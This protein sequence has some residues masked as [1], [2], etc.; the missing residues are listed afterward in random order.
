MRL[1]R[2]VALL[3]AGWVLC[4]GSAEAQFGQINPPNYGPGYRGN[5]SPYLNLRRGTNTGIDYYLGTRSEFQRRRDAGQFNN[6]IT[7]LQNR[8]R[9]IEDDLAGAVGPVISGTR[10]MFNTNSLYF[11]N[12]MGYFAGSG[13]PT[14]V[15]RRAYNPPPGRSTGRASRPS[16]TAV[17]RPTTTK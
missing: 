17:P 15:G 10:P 6:E 1:T 7:D 12:T 11:N 4:A 14:T 13:G 9:L 16:N 8:D 5:I 2:L 3:A